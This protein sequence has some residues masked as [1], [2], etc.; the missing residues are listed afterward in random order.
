[1]SYLSVD[2]Y[3]KGNFSTFIQ[4]AAEDRVGRIGV[5]LFKIDDQQLHEHSRLMRKP[6]AG[7]LK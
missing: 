6:Y 3:R 2:L 4:A 7:S 1:L 5:R